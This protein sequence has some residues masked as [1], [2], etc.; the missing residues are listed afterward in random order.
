M[1]RHC[2]SSQQ[3]QPILLQAEANCGRRNSP[4]LTKPL[5]GAAMA[6][7]ATAIKL[8]EFKDW[9]PIFGAAYRQGRDAQGIY[10]GQLGR[11]HVAQQLEAEIRFQPSLDYPEPKSNYRHD[12]DL[13]TLKRSVNSPAYNKRPNPYMQTTYKEAFSLQ[14]YDFEKDYVKYTPVTHNGP[15]KK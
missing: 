5:S 10:P 8:R 12:F 6:G 11:V 3:R 4:Q 7:P 14:C 1:L 9:T 2:G 15:L 13:L